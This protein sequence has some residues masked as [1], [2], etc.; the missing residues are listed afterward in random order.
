MQ[1]RLLAHV[2]LS[3]LLVLSQHLAVAHGYVHWAKP[4]PHG[5]ATSH[6]PGSQS[7]KSILPDH[8]C[9]LCVA[10]MQFGAVLGTPEFLFRARDCADTAD[11]LFHSVPA[12]AQ[13]RCA[14]RSRAPPLSLTA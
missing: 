14:Y 2:L 6:L 10:G 12:S 9:A 1:N 7:Q 4:A 8:G 13:T 5:T 11:R 3:L